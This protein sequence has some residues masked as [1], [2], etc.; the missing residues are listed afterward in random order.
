MDMAVRLRRRSPTAAGRTLAEHRP[1][2]IVGAGPVGL[3][4]AI[5]LEAARR[6]DGPARGREQGPGEAR[7]GSRAICYAKRSLEI[8]DRLGV[9]Q[10]DARQGRDLAA[11][12]GLLARQAGLP[13]RPPARGRPSHAGLRQ[14]PAVLSRAV[15]DRARASRWTASSCAG[16]TR[17]PASTARP[18]GAWLEVGSAVG[19]YRARV[20]LAARLRRHAQHRPPQPRAEGRGPG[21]PGPVPDHRRQDGGGL[22][23]RALVLVRSAVSSRP[24]GPAAQPAGSGLADRSAARPGRRCRGRGDQ[25]RARRA[26]RCGRC[27]DRSGAFELVWTSIYTFRCRRLARFRHGRIIFLGD[28]AHEVSPFGARGFNSGI[29]DADNLAWKLALVLQ[30]LAPERAARQL[31]RGAPGRGRREHPALDALDRVHHAQERGEPHL[32]RCR[33]GAGRAPSLRPP[34]DQQR[35]AV[36]ADPARL[37]V[38]QHARSGSPSRRPRARIAMR[39]RPAS[40]RR[41]ALLAAQPAGSRHDAAA[42]S[43]P[44]EATQPGRSRARSMPCSASR[45][46]SRPG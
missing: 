39:R 18:D 37:L 30:D 27:S 23:A 20:R 35:P 38:A 25:A 15:S 43:G 9:G 4:L 29:Q 36:D 5:D 13:V 28:A 34:D 22:P 12:Q 8:L 31:R 14:L 7:L 3:S 10:A 24:V 41:R 46:R 1:V 2:V 21:V 33:S 16:A 45:C 26:T 42:V 17:S 6:R 32:S 44:V 40:A 19:P 11:G